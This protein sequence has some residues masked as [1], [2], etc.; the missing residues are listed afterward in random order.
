[1]IKTY[2]IIV[3]DRPDGGINIARKND[4]FNPLELLGIVEYV[5][6][7]ILKQ[8]ECEIKPTKVVREVIIDKDDFQKE[9][10]LNSLKK[11]LRLLGITGR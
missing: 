11:I 9:P 10:K 2:T 6:L 1:M 5:Q 7:E 4:G 3:E 8:M